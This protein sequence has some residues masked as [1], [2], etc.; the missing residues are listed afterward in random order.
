[1]S[2]VI[3][4]QNFTSL[5]RKLFWHTINAAQFTVIAIFQRTSGKKHQQAMTRGVEEGTHWTVDSQSAFS[6]HTGWNQNQTWIL[7]YRL[8]ADTER[9]D[10]KIKY[11]GWPKMKK[12][13]RTDFPLAPT[14][15]PA[16][17]LEVVSLRYPCQLSLR[18]RHAISVLHSPGLQ[19]VSRE[20]KC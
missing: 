19:K 15:G 1:M 10:P 8:T 16:A 6:I 14:R 7:S 12:R 18:L 4:V 3:T 2:L 9:N 5:S 17:P 20:Q 13:Y 11:V